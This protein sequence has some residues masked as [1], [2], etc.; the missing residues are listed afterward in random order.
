[1][2]G[3]Q[4]RDQFVN[5]SPTLGDLAEPGVYPAS[6]EAAEDI[7]RR[8]LT[9]KSR[10]RLHRKEAESSAKELR[11]GAMVQVAKGQLRGP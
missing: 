3:E 8:G 1:M 9:A 2:G 10:V 4:W 6:P 7:S 5:G 11:G